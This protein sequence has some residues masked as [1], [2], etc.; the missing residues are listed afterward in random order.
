[1]LAARTDG[2]WNVLRRRGRQH[3]NDVVR[4][5]FQRL[6]QGVESSI[7]DLMSFVKNVNFET[8][9]G[10]TVTRGLTK[11]ADFVDAAVG[12]GIDF[13]N[14]DRVSGADFSAR[15]TYAAGLGN[16]VILGAAVGEPQPECE[17]QSSCRYP[18]AR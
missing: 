17:L 3:E 14:V 16:R 9:A 18:G 5:L 4:R 1:M 11:F 13:N 7:S 15:L 8:V 10:R 12:G 6:Q 2:L